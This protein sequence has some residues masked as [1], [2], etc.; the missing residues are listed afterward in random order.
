MYIKIYNNSVEE[1][2]EIA[3]NK[4]NFI[5]DWC[6]FGIINAFIIKFC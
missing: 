2:Q 1:V 3:G 6:L 5:K 4:K